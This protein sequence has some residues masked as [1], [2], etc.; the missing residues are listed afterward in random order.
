MELQYTLLLLDGITHWQGGEKFVCAANFVLRTSRLT[1]LAD[2]V[3]RLRRKFA[4]NL[5][6]ATA[7]PCKT[8]SSASVRS[9]FL[10]VFPGVRVNVLGPSLASFRLQLFVSIYLSCMK[11]IA[12][13]HGKQI[14]M[15][16]Q[17]LPL[18]TALLHFLPGECSPSW[19]I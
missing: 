11:V 7:D 14:L 10:P 9:T 13:L 5:S 12:L 2:F 16:I 18:D 19:L 4:N 1:C 3:S 8:A 6:G 17:T 15:I